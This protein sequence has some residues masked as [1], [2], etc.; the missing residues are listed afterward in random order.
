MYNPDANFIDIV[1]TK[2]LK[3]SQ[4]VLPVDKISALNAQ[5]IDVCH[6]A[7]QISNAL[8]KVVRNNLTE[9]QK[10]L[11]P[12]TVSKSKQQILDLA[13]NLDDDDLVIRLEKPFNGGVKYD[14]FK[15]E[16]YQYNPTRKNCAYHEI[17][18]KNT[19]RWFADIDHSSTEL[20][21]QFIMICQ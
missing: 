10:K 8:L 3:R 9:E 17:I 16:S 21:Q 15:Q 14:F 2:G 18:T 11:V 7:V 5:S 12:K 4:C 19:V 1:H 20:F 6:H 13:D